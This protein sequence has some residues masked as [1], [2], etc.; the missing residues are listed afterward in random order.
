VKALAP[1][2]PTTKTGNRLWTISDD[3]SINMLTPP[4]TQ[5]PRGRRR[6]ASVDLECAMR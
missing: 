6:G 1:S 2:V 3:T 4:S 5:M